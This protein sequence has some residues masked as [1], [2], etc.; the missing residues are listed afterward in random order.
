[1]LVCALHYFTHVPGV[2]SVVYPIV[3]HAYYGDPFPLHLKHYSQ[4]AGRPLKL[5]RACGIPVVGVRA[6]D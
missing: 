3:D 1:M 6:V 2:N 5:A 4:K